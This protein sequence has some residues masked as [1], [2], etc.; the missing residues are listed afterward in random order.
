MTRKLLKENS[1]G[2]Y[3]QLQKHK[4]KTFEFLAYIH[5]HCI[6]FSSSSSSFSSF[7]LCKMFLKDKP[8]QITISYQSR[9]K[10]KGVGQG[11]DLNEGTI[12]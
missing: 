1:K 2:K 5:Y 4:I 12:S 9:P 3:L 7:L 10:G 11:N 6:Y 8:N